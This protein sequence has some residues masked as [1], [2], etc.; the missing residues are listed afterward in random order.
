MLNAEKPKPGVLNL[1][2]ETT[3]SGCAA[4][5]D[6]ETAKLKA[7]LELIERDALL[8]YWRTQNTPKLI[9]LSEVNQE[10]VRLLKVMGPWRKKI[11]F[12]YLNTGFSAVTVQAVFMGRP[13]EGE[14][15]FTSTCA[16]RLEAVDAIEKAFLELLYVVTGLQGS[17]IKVKNYYG[18]NFDNSIWDFGDHAE[19]Y[20]SHFSRKAYEF[21]LPPNPPKIRF[22]E[23]PQVKGG[24]SSDQLKVLVSDFRRSGL[25]LFLRSNTPKKIQ[26]AGFWVYRAFSPDLLLIESVHRYRQLGAQRYYRLAAKLRLRRRPRKPEELNVWPHPLP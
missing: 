20:A 25:R 19:L 1:F 12:F 17:G 7:V 13:S 2:G 15:F 3:S 16:T 9:E 4:A 26:K 10:T 14:P 22:S 18:K 21:L 24:N 23:I 11:K 8:F 6:A 5:M